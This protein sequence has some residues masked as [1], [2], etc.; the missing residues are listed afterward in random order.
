MA[1]ISS[2]S[3]T[4]LRHRRA[5]LRRKRRTKGFQATWRTLAIVGTAIG[6]AWLMTHTDWVIHKPEQIEVQGNQRLSDSTVR[7]MLSLPYPQSVLTLNPEAIANQLKMSAHISQAYVR[8]SL[9]PPRL[10]VI[11]VERH[12][13][14]LVSPYPLPTTILTQPQ[15]RTTLPPSVGLIDDQGNFMPLRDYVLNPQAL[16]TIKLRVIGINPAQYADW[17]VMYPLIRD[18]AVPITEIDWRNPANIILK[19]S[20]GVVHFGAYGND[21]PAQLKALEELRPLTSQVKL[22]QIAYIDLR[23]PKS[24]TLEMR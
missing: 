8:R 23:N 18:S 3:P 19:T 6:I 22:S 7:S 5:Q 10:M 17:T 12:P 13:V 24:P 20:M 1:G 21:F 9:F 16:S 15:R 4:E 2:I 11:V 14:A